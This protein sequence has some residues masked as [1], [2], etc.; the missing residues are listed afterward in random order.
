[1]E[2]LAPSLRVVIGVALNVAT[3]TRCGLG[4]TSGGRG[5]GHAIRTIQ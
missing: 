4:R 5:V 3:K 1:M 2:T